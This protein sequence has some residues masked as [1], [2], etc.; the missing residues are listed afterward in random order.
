MYTW[1]EL[2]GD[3]LRGIDMGSELRYRVA[4]NVMENASA[5]RLAMESETRLQCSKSQKES[6]KV[7]VKQEAKE[8]RKARSGS[9]MSGN[10]RI[11]RVDRCSV[12]VSSVLLAVLFWANKNFDSRYT[13]KFLKLQYEYET[14]RGS[15]DIGVDDVYIVLTFIVVFC[16]SRS[17]L[18]EFMLKPVARKRFGLTSNKALQRFGE[19]GWSLVYYTFSWSVGFYLYYYSPYFLN[20]D[21]IYQGWPHDRMSGLFKTYYLFQIAAWFHQIIVLNVEE[22]R[23]DHWQMF[24]HHIIT[25]ALTTGS[26][27]YYFT[28]IGHVILILMDIVDVMLSSAKMLKYCGFSTLCDVMFV[29]FLFWWIML[30][31]VAYNY[32]VYRSVSIIDG[33]LDGSRCVAGVVQKRCLTPVVN[34]TFITLLCGLQ[35]I[36]CIWMYLILKVFVKVITGTGAEDVRSDGEESSTS[37]ETSDDIELMDEKEEDENED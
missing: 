34:N 31:H 13:D 14:S 10:E 5:A 33:L 2:T 19:Q 36:T 20:I 29:V 21:H 17:F 25:V 28:R 7:E 9:G 8:R 32:I 16:L 3:F 22:R 26:Y 35:V 11:S 12:A 18:L 27:Y 4:T 37:E 30:R 6:S 15:Y 23:K 1:R 24:A